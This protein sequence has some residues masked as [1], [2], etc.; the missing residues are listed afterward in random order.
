MSAPKQSFV[1]DL[2]RVD[3]DRQ[4]RTGADAQEAF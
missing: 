2:D 4:S 1:A 3:A